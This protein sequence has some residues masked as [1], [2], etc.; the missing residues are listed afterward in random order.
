MKSEPPAAWF[1]TVEVR[2]VYS[3]RSTVRIETVRTPEGTEVEREVIEHRDAVAVVPV[4]DD[5]DVL[6]VRQYRQALRAYLVEIPAGVLDV[7]DEAPE[8][9]A[10]RELL[11]EV[12]H[13]VADMRHLTTIANS[14]GWT[15]ERTHIYLARG[16]RPARTP[17]G[18]TPAA[19][20]ADMEV[21]RIP[22][23][24]AVDSVR[25]GELSDAKTVVGLS[26]AALELGI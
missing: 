21:V 14:A 19:E 11:E 5:G 1:E 15:N 25:A 18:F 2:E 10:R 6:L 22:L 24:D 13:D 8:T 9:A 3:G 4:T 20:E 17:D 23:G 26:L 16:V 7:D 12:E